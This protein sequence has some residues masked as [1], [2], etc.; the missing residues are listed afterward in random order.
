[1]IVK[2]NGIKAWM[3]ALIAVAIVL[4]ILLLI[5]NLILFLLPIIIILF[6]VSYFFRI[7]NKLKKGKK[8]DH[9]DINFRIKK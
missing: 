8:S 4:G 3:F 1:M 7:L 2:I 5:F 9:I 6:L